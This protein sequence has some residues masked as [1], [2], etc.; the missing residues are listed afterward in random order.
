RRN[1]DANLPASH[2]ME[3]NFSVAESF[4]GGSI[5]N[6]PGVLLKNE[7]LVQGQPLTGA[8]ARIV[9]NSFLFALSSASDI[10]VENNIQLLS[11]RDWMDLAMVYGTGRR[12]ILTLEKGE[13]GQA[14]FED[15]L[16]AWAAL[17]AEAAADSPEED[18]AAPAED[19][20]EAAEGATD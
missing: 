20:A 17:D 5:A 11:E 10:D 15:V 8:S 2:L 14:I 13:D 3:V 9:G 6:L 7:E 16:A 18:E 4:I 1:A 12:A 19:A